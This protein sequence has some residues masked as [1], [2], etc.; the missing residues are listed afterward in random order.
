MLPKEIDEYVRRTDFV[1]SLNEDNAAWFNIS[2][3]AGRFLLKLPVDISLDTLHQVLRFGQ[4]QFD[5]GKLA[6]EQELKSK[7]HSLLE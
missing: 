2:D 6:G 7:F 4:R 1:P 3:A 5:D